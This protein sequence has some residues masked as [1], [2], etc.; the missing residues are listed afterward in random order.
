MITL[1]SD[2]P[3][4][5]YANEMELFGRLAGLWRTSIA[6]FPADGS[7]PRMAEG[8]W[9]FGYALEG[10][11]VIDVWQIPSRE[12][13]AGADRAADQECGLCVRI[14]DPGLQLWRFTFHSTARTLVIHMYARQI[15]TE[16]VMERAE[17]SHLVRWIFSEIRTDSF[18]WRSERSLDGGGT[19]RVE[20]EVRATRN[21][22]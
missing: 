12:T 14:W 16:I 17:A 6:Y 19:W 3:C 10:R 1:V 15:G 21:R 18:E 2:Q 22:P 7:P 20:Q 8:D 9:E 11:A 5:P 13:L 4:R